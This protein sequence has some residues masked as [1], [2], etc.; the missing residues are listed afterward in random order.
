MCQI[1]NASME[2]VNKAEIECLRKELA[3]TKK[4]LAQCIDILYKYG[5][6]F[7]K[8]DRDTAIELVA[9]IKNRQD[10]DKVYNIDSK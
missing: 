8:A 4:D 10:F 3:L 1:N 7:D 2:N 5:H 9:M 6:T